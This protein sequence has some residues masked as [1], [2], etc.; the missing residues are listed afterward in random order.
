M[1]IFSHLTIEFTDY[2]NLSC[3]IC[4]HGSTDH[5]HAHHPK[6]YLPFDLFAMLIDTFCAQDY[7]FET[8]SLFWLGESLVHPR[9]GDLFDY[10][11]QKHKEKQFCRGIILHTNALALS[12]ARIEQL[13]DYARWCES[14]D[15]FIHVYISLDAVSEETYHTVKGAAG[16]VIQAAERVKRLVERRVDRGVHNP[17]VIPSFVVSPENRKEA[18][19]FLETWQ[20]YLGSVSNLPVAVI[21]DNPH[22]VQSDGVFFQRLITAAQPA[23]NRLYEKVL[24]DIGVK[25]RTRTKKE[26][27]APV[28]RDPEKRRP[29][30]VPWKEMCVSAQGI[31]TPCSLDENL[32]LAIGDLREK[33]IEEIWQ[34]PEAVALRNAHIRGRFTQYPL[35]AECPAYVQHLLPDDE[36][37]DYLRQYDDQ[38]EICFFTKRFNIVTQKEKTAAGKT[39]EEPLSVCLVSREYPGETGWGGIGTYTQHLA[40]GLAGAGHRVHVISEST[41]RDRSYTE[42]GVYVHR[43]MSRPFFKDAIG[44][45]EFAN[46]LEYSR[47]LA[48]VI[49]A[50]DREHGFDIV[51][52]PNFAGEAYVY[53]LERKK[54]LVT[55]LHTTFPHIVESL[56]W[57]WTH[58]RQMSWYLE[59]AT[60]VHSDRIVS[61]TNAH[62]QTVCRQMGL[63]PSRV[64]IIPLGIPAPAG[65]GKHRCDE[66]FR[67]LFVG[68]LEKRKGVDVLLS[69]MKTVFQQYPD[70]ELCMI[71]RDTFTTETM[72]S[73]DGTPELSM[74]RQLLLQVPPRYRKKIHFL[75]YVSDTEREHWYAH[76]DLF[77]APS[78]YESFGFVYIEAMAQ[79]LPVIGC[80]A[81][82]IPEVVENGK[83][84]LLVPPDDAPSL[85]S[86][87]GNLIDDRVRRR[88]LGENARRAFHD[89]F[90][91][92]KMVA[93]TVTLYRDAITR[94]RDAHRGPIKTGN[95]AYA[96]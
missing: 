63:M 14:S 64:E 92:D 85:A 38:A 56:G 30:A 84:G 71:G 12:D 18:K 15:C 34:G 81:G 19:R 10:F 94:F 13:L 24:N 45:E 61:S 68:R 70:V 73:F 20:G 77:V 75:D 57:Q 42:N 69:A 83:T 2:C 26:R 36:A 87:I 7:L 32:A 27:Q 51:E 21:H 82:G 62:A 74:K 54:P 59:Q 48:A 72:V 29:C 25:K 39:G 89:A 88:T 3:T 5:M 22:L 50:G 1:K 40:E 17:C 79:G 58:D 52:G 16:S 4:K 9:Y 91:A 96:Q 78:R 46:R 33:T 86:A 6:T 55:R 67:I 41:T 80:A 90:S 35:C 53:S 66:K 76:S 44:I 49:Q 93:R 95:M 60:V 8:V 43:I 31:V 65:D 11:I 28:T 23:A 37:I 47:R